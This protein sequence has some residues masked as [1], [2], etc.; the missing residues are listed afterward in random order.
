[1]KKRPVSADRLKERLLLLIFPA[2]ALGSF[3][4][5]LFFY[6]EGNVKLETW[7]RAD[8][9]VVELV[10]PRS[11]HVHYVPMLRFRAADGKE[12]TARNDGACGRLDY[13]VGEWVEVLYC[14]EDPQEA[15]IPSNSFLYARCYVSALF[16]GLLTLFCLLPVLGPL[17]DSLGS[18]PAR[19]K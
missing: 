18:R 7:P 2:L 3:L 4:L 8:A 12:Y 19:C 16:C 14:P 17:I 6:H 13:Q 11:R 5:T 9:E 1:M 15:V 10:K